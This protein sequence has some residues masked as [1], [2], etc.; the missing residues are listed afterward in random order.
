VEGENGCVLL[1]GPSHAGKT[2]TLQG[3]TGHQRGILPRA[4]EEVLSIIKNSSYKQ[5]ER[6]PQ[7]HDNDTPNS[8]SMV[9]AHSSQILSINQ[10]SGRRKDYGD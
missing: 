4:V 7:L 2:Y 6:G 10:F 1:F 9:E 3:K 5:D 8:D